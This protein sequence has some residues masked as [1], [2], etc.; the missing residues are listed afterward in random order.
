M[1]LFVTSLNSGSNG[2]C[3]YIGNDTEAVLIDAGISCRETERRMKRLGLS[4]SLVKAIFVSHEHIDHITGIPALSK[5]Y[6]LPVY[7]TEATLKNSNIPVQNHLIKNFQPDKT[8]MAGRLSVK[9]FPKSHDAA[10]PYSFVISFNKLNIGVFTDIGYACRNMKK[11]FP[12]CHAAFLEANYCENMLAKGN[13]PAH[14]KKR[15]SSN[16]GHLSNT[17]ALDLFIKH[18][19]AHLSHIFLS[20]LSKNNNSPDLVQ[21][22]FNQ[23]AGTTQ[24]IVASRY[25]ETPVFQIDDNKVPAIV[26][27]RKNNPS[28][29]R[30]LSLFQ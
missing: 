9:P 19:G 23:H 3:Y 11:Y 17:Q 29:T 25:H 1:S 15:I 21:Q 6:Q 8:I 18:R 2:N 20:H 12:Q 27:T 14:L 10:D 5:K 30:Q 24:V 4:L 16:K 22:L 7:I 13:Y 26:K 28:A